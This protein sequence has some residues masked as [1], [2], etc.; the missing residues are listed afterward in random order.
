MVRPQRLPRRRGRR[1]DE[2][3]RRVRRRGPRRD[4]RARRP[5]ARISELRF[6][7]NERT[8]DGFL[9]QR[10]ELA[11]GD[12]YDRNAVRRAFGELYATG[13]FRE[14]HIDLLGDGPTRGRC[15]CAWSRRTR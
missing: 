3:R 12:L 1:V 10:V 11:P 9:R 5:G 6:E 8:R 14:I 7:G 2:L 15:A 4:A 13:L